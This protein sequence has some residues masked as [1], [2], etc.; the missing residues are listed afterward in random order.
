MKL[1]KETS[2]NLQELQVLEQNM[3]GF[4]M[5][6][7]AFQMELNETEAA[8]EE[9]KKAKP[10]EVYRILGQIMVKTEKDKAEQELEDKKNLLTLR[11]KS[12]EKQEKSIK[13]RVDS[14]REK[15]TKKMSSK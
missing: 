10:N 13:D 6:K 7:Q 3:Q 15:V 5:Q 12:I 2:E 9:L 1:D 11:L 8:L 14:L 4:L